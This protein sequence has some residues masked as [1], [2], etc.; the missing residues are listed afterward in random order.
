M[1]KTNETELIIHSH[2]RLK[3]WLLPE[4]KELYINDTS[5]RSGALVDGSETGAMETPPS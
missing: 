2:I 3:E 1:N 4:V 5:Y